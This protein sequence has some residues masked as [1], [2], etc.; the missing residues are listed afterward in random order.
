MSVDCVALDRN[1]DGIIVEDP[2]SGNGTDRPK[3]V[4]EL[5]SAE[6]IVILVFRPLTGCCD[7]NL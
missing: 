6:R 4:H 1:E 2:E 5:S 7:V 3:L